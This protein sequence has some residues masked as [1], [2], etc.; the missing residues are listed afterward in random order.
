VIACARGAISL[1]LKI[2]FFN[3]LCNG[4][5]LVDVSLIVSGAGLPLAAYFIHIISGSASCQKQDWKH[6]HKNFCPRFQKVNKY[7]KEVVGDRALSLLELSFHQVSL[8]PP[9][10]LF[11]SLTPA[12]HLRISGR[13]CFNPMIPLNT[14]RVRLA[15]TISSSTQNIYEVSFD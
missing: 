13:K 11:L 1:P 14:S 2:P 5:Q 3:V 6:R 15:V 9:S 10:H 8:L 7:D 4:V 12:M